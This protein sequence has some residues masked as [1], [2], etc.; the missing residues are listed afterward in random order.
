[1]GPDRPTA[2]QGV[3]LLLQEGP[4]QSLCGGLR[5]PLSPHDGGIQAQDSSTAQLCPQLQPLPVGVKGS[6]GA[7]ARQHLVLNTPVHAAS[8]TVPGL[9]E[10]IK[11]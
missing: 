2:E 9:P 4:A 8:H 11:Q 6:Y 5:I 3:S 1:M 10:V 7:T